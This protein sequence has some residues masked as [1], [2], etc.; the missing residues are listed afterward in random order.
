MEQYDIHN[1]QSKLVEQ[2]RKQ[3]KSRSKF[4]TITRT[5]KI[6]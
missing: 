3:H 2:N 6:G 1:R 5:A 4:Y